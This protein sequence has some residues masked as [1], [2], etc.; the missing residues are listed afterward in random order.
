[1][2]VV[3]P[4]LTRHPFST[5]QTDIKSKLPVF[6]VISDLVCDSSNLIPPHP[7]ERSVTSYDLNLLLRLDYRFNG[8]SVIKSI[9]VRQ[10]E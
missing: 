3:N 5:L 4:V 10:I 2:I 1:M 6:A 7:Q 8:V 9:S